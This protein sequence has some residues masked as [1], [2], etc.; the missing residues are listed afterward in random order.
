MKRK[1]PRENTL[2]M[3]SLKAIILLII[4]FLLDSSHGGFPIPVATSVLSLRWLMSRRNGAEPLK[5]RLHLTPRALGLR[6]R[7]LH[8]VIVSER[9][10]VY[11][12]NVLIGYSTA[13]R[14]ICYNDGWRKYRS[15]L[16]NILFRRN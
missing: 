2:E 12:W 5:S 10:K 4:E 1:N 3:H 14:S 15:G 9:V 7:A 11:V 8:E 16:H 6:R 13:S